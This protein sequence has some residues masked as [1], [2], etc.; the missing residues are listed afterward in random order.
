MISY[1]NVYASEGVHLEFGNRHDVL[2]HNRIRGGSF[3]VVRILLKA[4][5]CTFIDFEAYGGSRA[6]QIIVLYKRM[7]WASIKKLVKL[8]AELQQ[9]FGL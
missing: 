6:L 7:K 8:R 1:E 3:C 9:A 4:F 5:L 2:Y